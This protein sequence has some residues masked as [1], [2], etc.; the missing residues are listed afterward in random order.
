[1]EARL[2]LA[3]MAQRYR[4]ALAPGQRVATRFAGTLSPRYGMRMKTLCRN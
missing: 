4:L 1:M 2:V 3:T